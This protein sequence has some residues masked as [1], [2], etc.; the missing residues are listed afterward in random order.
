MNLT[1]KSTRDIIVGVI[2]RKPNTGVKDFVHEMSNLLPLSQQTNKVVY[3]TTNSFHKFVTYT[4]N[5]FKRI[6]D[7]QGSTNL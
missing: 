4:R 3:C 7:C 2:Y 6:K 5:I 1:V